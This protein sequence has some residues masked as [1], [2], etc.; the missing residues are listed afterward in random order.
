MENLSSYEE[1]SG[2]THH[3]SLQTCFLTRKLSITPNKFPQKYIHF[4]LKS[5]KGYVH[6]DIHTYKHLF[7]GKAAKVLADCS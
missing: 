6:T 7:L 1:I 2:V 5:S 4:F 3:D